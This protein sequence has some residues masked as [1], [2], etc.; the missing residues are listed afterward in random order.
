MKLTKSL[1]IAALVM[2]LAATP[3]L[4]QE[5]AE[6]SAEATE[7]MDLIAPSVDFATAVATANQNAEGNIVSMELEYFEDKPMYAVALEGET[8]F[9]MLLIDAV[10][11]NVVAS[12]V[13]KADS[14]ET[15]ELLFADEDFDEDDYLE[16][17]D[18][19]DFHDGMED[20]DFDVD[21]DDHEEV[22]Q[23]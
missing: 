6:A 14:A 18:E 15:L 10:S 5:T 3:L 19:A 21:M 8:S 7:T 11:G 9:S 20:Y 23:G 16:F 12:N 4:A 17:M 1:P 22:D 13:M 2:T